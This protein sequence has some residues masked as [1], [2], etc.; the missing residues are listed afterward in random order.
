MRVPLD[1]VNPNRSAT[2]SKAKKD[3]NADYDPIKYPI[4]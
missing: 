1:A 3:A 4:S 2:N